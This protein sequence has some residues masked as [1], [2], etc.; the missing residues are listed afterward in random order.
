M[1]LATEHFDVHADSSKRAQA[2]VNGSLGDSLA[3]V[4]TDANDR[5]VL[6]CKLTRKQWLHTE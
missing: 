1:E 5:T 2:K 3:I 6:K 4:T